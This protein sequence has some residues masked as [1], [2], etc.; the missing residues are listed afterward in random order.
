MYRGES[1]ALGSFD[2]CF[3]HPQLFYLRRLRI[4]RPSHLEI[5]I[6]RDFEIVGHASSAKDGMRCCRIVDAVTQQRLVNMNAHDLTE[7][8]PCLDGISINRFELKNLCATTFKADGTLL[9][10]RNIHDA[11]S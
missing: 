5:R 1:N 10:Q 3:T 9:D 8:Q 11:S 6:G 2:R 4:T 7:Y